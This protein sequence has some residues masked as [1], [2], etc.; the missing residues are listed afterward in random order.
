MPIF[1]TDTSKS[2]CKEIANTDLAQIENPLMPDRQAW[3]ER[4]S[5]FHWNFEELRSGECWR[6]MRQFI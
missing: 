5:M 4:L 1:V 2:Q 6:H 3:A